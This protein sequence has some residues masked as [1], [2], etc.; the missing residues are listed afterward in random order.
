MERQSLNDAKKLKQVKK[1]LF[2]NRKTLTEDQFSDL[3]QSLAQEVYAYA[4]NEGWKAR[5]QI[6]R[7][8]STAR[9]IRMRQ[10]Y[11]NFHAEQVAAIRDIDGTKPLNLNQLEIIWD[12]LIRDWM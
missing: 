11:S 12:K 1:H 4:Y 2:D 10:D 3:I 9:R 5:N 6:T 7:S 8:C